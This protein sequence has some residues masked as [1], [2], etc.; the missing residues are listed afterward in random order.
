MVLTL[1]RQGLIRR[2]PGQPR[3]IQVLVAPDNIPV[4]R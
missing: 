4:L 2:Q 3:S 1:E